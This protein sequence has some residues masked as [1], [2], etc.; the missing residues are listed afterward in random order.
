MNMIE[1]ENSAKD[2]E[3]SLTSESTIFVPADNDGRP[4]SFQD[5]EK[6]IDYETTREDV[7]RMASL[8]QPDED[9]RVVADPTR[10]RYLG[11]VLMI[12]RTH[13]TGPHIGKRR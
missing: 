12:L 10:S 7:E 5:L 3:Y 11:M 9:G 13:S 8:N 2:R 4:Q 6:G 1:D